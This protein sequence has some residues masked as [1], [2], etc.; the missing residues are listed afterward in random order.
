MV[1]MCKGV[2]LLTSG[3]I[4]T[5]KAK[6][7]S[8]LR[9]NSGFLYA[10]SAGDIHHGQLEKVFLIECAEKIFSYAVVSEYIP[11][12][13]RLCKDTATNVRINDH[14]IVLSIPRLANIQI[15]NISSSIY[16]YMQNRQ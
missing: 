6:A 3:R 12:S 1:A 2:H 16:Y 5:A 10:D 11:T 9:D 8:C 15:S 14:I 4:I 13:E 7:K